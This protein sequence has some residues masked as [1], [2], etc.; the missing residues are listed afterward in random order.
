MHGVALTLLMDSNHR[1]IAAKM[2]TKR[3]V[4]LKDMKK[5]TNWNSF[6]GFSKE[7]FLK[8]GIYKKF[9]NRAKSVER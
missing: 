6:E 7:E 5:E 8:I 2:A 4:I 9:L 1:K 3:P